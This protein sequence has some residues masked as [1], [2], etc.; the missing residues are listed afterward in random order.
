MTQRG[1]TCVLLYLVTP[2]ANRLK[3]C[4][5]GFLGLGLGLGLGFGFRRPAIRGAV[6]RKETLILETLDNNILTGW[7]TG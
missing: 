2:C 1:G 4:C 5:L 6:A 7:H 3:F